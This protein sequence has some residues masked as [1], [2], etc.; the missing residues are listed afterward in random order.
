MD[1]NPSAERFDAL[2]SERALSVLMPAALMQ[3]NAATQLGSRFRH[4]VSFCHTLAGQI[5]RIRNACKLQKLQM[6]SLYLSTNIICKF[7]C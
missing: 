5:N 3:L 1:T 2:A 4:F 7:A 6:L